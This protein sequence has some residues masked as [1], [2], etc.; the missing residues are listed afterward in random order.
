MKRAPQHVR[1]GYFGKLP[2]RGDFIKAAENVALVAMLDRWLAEVMSRLSVDPRWKLHYD[3]MATLQFAFVG[4]RSHRAIAGQIHASSDQSRRRFPF[5]MMSALDIGDPGGFA[6][7]CPM[8]LAGLWSRFACLGAQVLAEADPGPALQLLAS[9]VIEVEPGGAAH[10][11][12]FAAFVEHQTLDGL[13]AM[14]VSARFPGSVR[15][16]ILALGLLLLPV[17]DSGGARPEKSLLLPVPREPGQ[18]ALVASFWL[19]LIMPFLL[20]SDVE[21]A[22]FFMEGKSGPVMVIGFRGA[23]PLTLQAIID[24]A[25]GAEHQIDFEE[26]EWVDEQIAA[27]HKVRQLSAYLEQRQLSL[28]S[29]LGLFHASFI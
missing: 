11:A 14:L 16:V 25:I 27:D 24:P 1:V 4:T 28:K 13:H 3:T 21:L 20:Q 19:H 5:L 18:R 9:S 12:D 10:V 6:P 8:V 23:D 15:H 26:M 2:A 22:L 7:A 29:A 17:R